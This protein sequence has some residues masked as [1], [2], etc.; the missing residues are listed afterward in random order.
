MGGQEETPS[1]VTYPSVDTPRQ[2]RF[3]TTASSS[4]YPQ[5]HSDSQGG[6]AM[7]EGAFEEQL[8][9]IPGAMVHLVDRQESVLLGSGELVVVRINQNEEQGVVALVRVG[10]DLQWPLMRDE[11]VV[12]LDPIHYVFSLPVVDAVTPEV[13]DSSTNQV[14]ICSLV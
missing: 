10:K 1:S 6:P 14:C 11:Q 12:K 8:V 7:A 2:S 3:T 4:L 13:R 9:S 5:I